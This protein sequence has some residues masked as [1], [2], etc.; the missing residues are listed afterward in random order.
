MGKKDKSTT[1]APSRFAKPSEAPAGGEGWKLE[2]DENDGELLL[3]TPLREIEVETKKYGEKK[4]IVADV[5]KIN[6]KKPEKSEE[7]E[8]VYVWAAWVQ[9]SLRA[10][11]G[12]MQVLGRLDQEADKSAGKGYVWKLQD[13]DDDDVAAAEAYLDSLSPFDKKSKDKKSKAA[14]AEPSK[15]DKK[16]KGKKSEPEPEKPAKKKSKK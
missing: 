11:I 3:F 8:E 5:V 13:A 10:S 7:H 9:G 14:T 4:V 12:D 15:A 2:S 6:T 16:G 1:A